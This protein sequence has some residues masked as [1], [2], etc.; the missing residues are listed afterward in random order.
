MYYFP[1]ETLQL[2]HVDCPFDLPLTLDV[3]GFFLYLLTLFE[4]LWL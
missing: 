1:V 4:L 2:P 3:R